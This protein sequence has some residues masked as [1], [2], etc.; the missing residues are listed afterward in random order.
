MLQGAKSEVKEL[1]ELIVKNIPCT[2]VSMERLFLS[3]KWIKTYRRNTMGQ[4]LGILHI[5]CEL[6]LS[7]GTDPNFCD[8]VIEDFVSGEKRIDVHY[9]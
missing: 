7:V 8:K 2:S 1:A 6:L 9:R 3:L 5:E 4:H